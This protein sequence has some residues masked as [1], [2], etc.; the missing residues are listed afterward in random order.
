ML[1]GEVA[2][3]RS[4]EVAIQQCGDTGIGMLRVLDTIIGSAHD[5]MRL[6]IAVV[7]S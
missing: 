6:P 7:V 5:T 2:K 4:G 1:I 3:W